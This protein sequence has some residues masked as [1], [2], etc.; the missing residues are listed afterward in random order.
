MTHREIE[1]RE[2]QYQTLPVELRE[3][4]KAYIER[5][6]RPGPFVQS[7]L[8]DSLGDALMTAE[9][10]EQKRADRIALIEKVIGW[11]HG[12]CPLK[13]YG[14]PS[15]VDAWCTRGGLFGRTDA[16]FVRQRAERV[17]ARLAELHRERMVAIGG[18]QNLP[19]FQRFMRQAT[20]GQS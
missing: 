18:A 20:G 19:A 12:Q 16:D 6:V 17:A 3:Q 8:D 5:G 9:F 11:I 15:I 4:M 13:A 7:L 2:V 14:T 1:A 10:F